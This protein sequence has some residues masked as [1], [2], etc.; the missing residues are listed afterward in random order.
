MDLSSLAEAGRQIE[1]WRRTLLLTHDRPDGDALGALAAMWRVFTAA[2]RDATAC[3]YGELLPRYAFLSAS[4]PFEQWVGG[5]AAQL[6]GRH[7]GIL[8]VD[9]G[10][11]SQVE[12]VAGYLRASSLP[13]IVVDHHATWDALDGAGTKAWYAGDPSSA[14]AC[15]LLFEWCR[16]MSWSLDP[17]AA[18]ALFVGMATD[19]G[20][21][22][23][24][25]TDAR[26]LTAAAELLRLGVRAD[27]L[28]ARLYESWSAARLRLKGQLLGTLEL[29]AEGRVASMVLTGEMLHAAGATPADS[30]E[31]IN[32]PMAVAEVV[33]SVLF[34]VLDDGRVR[35]NL[36]SKSPEVC[37]LDV[38]VSALARAFGGGGHRRAAG[39]RVV[40][41]LERVRDDILGGLVAAVTGGA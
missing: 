32:E 29:H 31:L 9:T 17:A 22:R 10:S 15:G 14:S 38:D 18:E 5:D 41:S 23:F 6:D 37:G 13:R 3:V 40:G 1:Q 34:S 16:L 26:T 12:P 25:N 21:F 8:I 20:W 39:V 7:D 33:A 19:T 35:V 24:S 2:G 4:C 11:W 27:V 28:Y 30:E 36:R